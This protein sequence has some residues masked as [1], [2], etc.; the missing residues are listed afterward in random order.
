MRRF[1][2]LAGVVLGVALLMAACGRGEDRPGQVTTESDNRGSGPGSASVSGTGTG[3]ATGAAPSGGPSGGAAGYQPVSSVDAHAAIGGD[4]ARIREALAP[5]KT[6]GAV[7]WAAVRRVW[8]EGGSSKKSDGSN[9]TLAKLVAAPEVVASVEEAIEGTGSSA[10]ASDAVRAQ[11]VDKGITVLLARKVVDEL[12]AAEKKVAEGK[13]DR[14]SGAPHNVDEGWAFLTAK[15]QGPA[16]TAEKRAADFKR[17]GKVLEP[18]IQGLKQAQ[19]AAIAGDA[20]RLSSASTAVRQGLDYVFYLATHKYLGAS[21]EVGRAE[22]SSFYLGI[23]PR[24]RQAVP[25]SDEAITAAFASG[26]AAAGRAALHEPAVLAA[27]GV[28]DSE[29]VDRP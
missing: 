2:T 8:S 12:A 23:K 4:A 14:A 26:D 16:T 5:A 22:G 28:D 18:I 24:V 21:D 20:S 19:E 3:S 6:G 15:G 13:L 29:R 11:R 7:D 27:L 25:A 9:R 17:E 10:G 1:V